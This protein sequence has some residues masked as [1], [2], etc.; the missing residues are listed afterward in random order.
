MI[1]AFG[2]GLLWMTLTGIQTKMLVK[3]K[4]EIL[5]VAWAFGTSMIWGYLVRI[6]VL[7]KNMILPYAI[8][9][10]IGAFIAY[11]IGKWLS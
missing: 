4:S 5:L 3:T 8:G 2:L 7:D 11:R 10:A 1:I 6:V 9:T